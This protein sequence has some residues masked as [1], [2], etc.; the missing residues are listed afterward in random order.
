MIF[1]PCVSNAGVGGMIDQRTVVGWRRDSRPTYIPTTQRN[2]WDTKPYNGYVL[3][4]RVGACVGTGQFVSPHLILTNKHVIQA[5]ATNGRQCSVF[6][7]N[8]KSAD[9][10]VIT[11]GGAELTGA[12][13]PVNTD[14]GFLRV[15]D[16]VADAYFDYADKTTIQ[17]GLMRA[18]FGA[19]RILSND[20]I[21]NIR[22]AYT[23]SLINANQSDTTKWNSLNKAAKISDKEK[24][25]RNK[26]II[27]PE[28]LN[29]FDEY[30]LLTGKDFVT[31]CM[32]D[33][34]TLKAIRGCGIKWVANTQF[35]HNCQ[36]WGGDSGSAL[37]G[38][39][40]LTTIVG[41]NRAG[42]RDIATQEPFINY[43]VPLQSIFSDKIK[44]MISDDR[45]GSAQTK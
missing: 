7:S 19:L 35:S 18:G 21:K 33:T 5:C 4:C 43:G 37:L 12:I 28:K 30:K 26:Y 45:I 31:D 1:M 9:A 25:H 15:N 10:D 2:E 23:R 34:T 24:E 3:I 14:W 16:V 6:L 20:D 41:I 39:P 32:S 17:D 27:A 8:G 38:G 44:Q 40:G 36:S 11:V 13:N 42:V 22:I 29:F